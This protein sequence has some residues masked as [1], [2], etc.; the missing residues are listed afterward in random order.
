LV[1][2]LA[3]ATS[4]LSIES[5][6]PDAFCPPQKETQRAVA[7]RLGLVELEGT[8]RATYV[9]VHRTRGDFVTLKLFDPAGALKLERQLPVQSGSCAAVADVMALMLERFFLRPEE[10]TEQGPSTE[11]PPTQV[12]P[13][14]PAAEPDRQPAAETRSPVVQQPTPPAAAPTA[15]VSARPVRRFWAGAE[16]W[17]STAWL[18]PSLRL[19]RDFGDSYR[20][21]F[22][23]GFDLR[24]HEA[25][26]FDGS[27]DL[28]RVPFSLSGSKL[29]RLSSALRARGG[30][31]L[32]GVL[33]LARTRALAKSG[34][35]ARLVP[36]L[37]ARLGADFFPTSPAQPFIEL[38]ASWL[39]G[40]FAPA[41]QVSQRDVLE[42]PALILG[43]SAGIQTPY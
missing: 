32:L 43:L 11:A 15:S 24:E 31:E 5:L 29:W 14:Q 30:L 33:E 6:S 26:V 23:A 10:L 27:A 18:A 35:G 28:R 17:A 13:D 12:T 25:S 7:A 21:G 38:T 39:L 2:I 19:A 9:L 1:P 22:G 37:G 34:K 36:G 8:W 42:P 3:L 40:F 4:G 41:F 16:L 20:L